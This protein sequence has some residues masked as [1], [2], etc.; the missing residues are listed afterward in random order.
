VTGLAANVSAQAVLYLTASVG[1]GLAVGLTAAGA[2]V[3]LA[4]AGSGQKRTLRHQHKII[5]GFTQLGGLVGM[6]SSRS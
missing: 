5:T 3:W 4:G 1:L 2:G 6:P